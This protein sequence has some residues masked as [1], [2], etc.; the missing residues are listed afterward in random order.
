MNT[1]ASMKQ[2]FTLLAIVILLVSSVPVKV[3]AEAGNYEHLEAAPAVKPSVGGAL[4]LIEN[5][6]RKT[7]GDAQGNPI[8]LRGMST[9]GLQ[10]YPEIINNNAFAALSHDWGANLIRL[11]MYVGEDGYATHPEIKQ[12]VIDGINYAIAND[13]YV[14][15]DWHVHNPGDPNAETYKGAKDFFQEISTLYPNDKHILYELANEPNGGNTPGVTNDAAGWA[16]VKSYAEPIIHMLRDNGNTNIVIVGSPNWSQRADLAADNP[17]ADD[18]TMYTVHFYTGTHM[19]SADSSDRTNVMSNAKYALEHGVALFATEWGTSEASGNNGPFLD[20]AD[21]WIEFLN[22]NNISWANWSLTNKSETSAAFL[23][24]EL[25]KSVGTKLDPGADQV[26]APEELTVSGEYVRARIKGI[27]YEPIDRTK[28]SFTTKL[29]DF[30]DGTLQGFG[31]NSDSPVKSVTLSNSSNALLLTG[32]SASSDI[33][34][35]NYWAN[36][37]LSVDGWSAQPDIFGAEKL[38]MD[39]IAAAPTTVSIAA[40]PQ[41]STHGWANPLRAVAVQPADFVQQDDSTYKAKLTITTA[42]SP[43]F[44][45][46]AKDTADSK[47]TNLIL[48]V[49]ASGTEEI[50]LDNLT[51]TGNRTVTEQ[52]VEHAPIGVA[53]L[54]SNFE[55]GTR[56]GWNWDA[57]SG[58]KTAL[59]IQDA[60]GSK[61]ISWDAAYPDVKPTDGWASAPRIMLGNI[62]ATRGDN[63]YFAFD[64]YL[65][66]ER[67]SAGVLSI[68]LALAP[69]T[70]G[71]W[72]QAA[73]NVDIPLAALS[74]QE[75]TSDGLYGYHAYFDLDHI[76]DG[77][78]LAADTLMRDISIIVADVGSDFAGSM[79]LDNVR[80][81]NDTEQEGVPAAPAD[82]S[83]AAGNGQVTLNWSTVTGATYYHVKRYG[84]SG[85]PYSAVGTNLSST[86]Y[87]DTNV[88]NGSTY[89]YVVTAS[90]SVGESVYSAEKAAVPV[91]K[92]TGGGGGG[93]STGTTENSEIMNLPQ[94][95]QAGKIAVAIAKGTAKVILPAKAANIDKTETIEL[96]NDQIRVQ[97]PGSVLQKLGSLVTADK[98][99]DATITLGMEPSS[100]GEHASLLDKAAHQNHA[101]VA[102]AGEVWNFTLAITDK[103]GKEVTLSQFDEPITIALQVDEHADQDLLG[104]YYIAEDGKLEYV[105]GKLIDGKM[106]A[107]IH[108]FSSYAVLSYDK[109]FSDVSESFWA[110]K[111]IKKLAAKHIIEG[112][113]DTDYAPS[114]E[115]TRAEF[116]AMIARAMGLKANR[117]PAFADIQSADWFAEPV[118]AA[119]EAGIVEGRAS[120]EFAPNETITREEMAVM[121]VRA[122]QIAKGVATSDGT[123]PEQPFA[124]GS[125]ISDWAQSSVKEAHALGLLNGRDEGQ[126][127]PQG[128]ATRAECAEVLARLIA[129]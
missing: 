2:F 13:M 87:V 79:F 33:S 30:N 75:K 92:S 76:K 116:T 27:P 25:G 9:H 94:A 74:Q 67:A 129:E 104:I 71:Y 42:D 85:G 50:A 52:P 14:I 31:V 20:K 114:K 44:D 72:A 90:N 29:W 77:K 82:L 12:K 59:T 7:L 120:S 118:A 81:T 49:G 11:A 115:V 98:L 106:E 15:V 113:N 54:P 125:S 53:A 103:D 46:I 58:V 121:L 86:T 56:Q 47:L 28:A 70:L 4:Q 1:K 101:Q 110:G 41:S 3:S 34:E 88:V 32:M 83:A 35:G 97:I 26:W 84:E 66:P 40:I 61:A 36:V 91:R 112:V 105:G 124:D 51:I 62:N 5:N 22:A 60:N 122:Y 107:A 37:R 95:D 127:V 99:E 117:I 64:F 18:N 78:V 128:T 111:A 8:Q 23:P 69:P 24:F 19:P 68:N 57:A 102:S 89:Y 45:S 96:S 17:I 39:V 73:E 55:D 108:H 63:K 16:A 119:S 65:K 21:D 38:T 43:N 100:P 123:K 109:S 10:W 80:F 126:F 48:F 93:T 6:G